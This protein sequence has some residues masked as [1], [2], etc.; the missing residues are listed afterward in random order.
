[1][2]TTAAREMLVGLQTVNTHDPGAFDPSPR[3][4]SIAETASRGNAAPSVRQS[5]A[6]AILAF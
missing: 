2:W 3:S 4:I 5:S 6:A 1:M